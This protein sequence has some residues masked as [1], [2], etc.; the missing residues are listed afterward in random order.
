MSKYVTGFNIMNNQPKKISITTA[1][2]RTKHCKDCQYLLTL[3]KKSYVWSFKDLDGKTHIELTRED[4]RR[5]VR[6]LRS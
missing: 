1:K 3:V 4:A 2:R 5:N 6:F